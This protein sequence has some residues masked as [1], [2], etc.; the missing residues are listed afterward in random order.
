[1]KLCIE[2]LSFAY[3]K[4]QVLEDV[5]FSLEQGEFLSVLGPNGVGKSTLFRCILG[6]LN[7]YQGRILADQEDL[8]KMPRKEMARRIAYIPQIHKPTFGYTV[9]DTVLMGTTRQVS[10]FSQPGKG[11]IA[12]AMHALERVGAAHLAERDFTYL[13]GGEQQ[14]VLVARAIAQQAEILVMDEP[15][16]ALDYGNQLRILELVRAL[17]QEGYGV[18]LSTHNPQ[19]A[20][21]FA[22]RILALSGGRIAAL[23]KP[24]EVLT[25]ALV[26]QLY[27]VN[28]AFAETEGG[29]VLVPLME[30]M[31]PVNENA[32]G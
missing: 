10:V 3:D 28:V 23:G 2:K 1:M 14:L 11:Q 20:L 17:S 19:H 26:S 5:S 13:S 31:Q 6:L 4:H 27:G 25:Q 16:S 15:T 30:R 29:R 12:Q 9:L 7:H 8:R 21:T 22:T 24:E 32:A 18:L